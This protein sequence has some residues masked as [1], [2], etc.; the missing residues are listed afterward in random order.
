[1]NNKYLLKIAGL[2]IT[3][4]NLGQ[5]AKT[6]ANKTL[7]FNRN[8]NVRGLAQVSSMADRLNKKVPGELK[9]KLGKLTDSY[10]KLRF[11]G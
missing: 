2:P 7:A 6:V 8:P 3:N 11:E 5:V 1:M 10:Q 9:G 4:S